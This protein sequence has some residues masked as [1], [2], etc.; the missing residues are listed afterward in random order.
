[1]ISLFEDVIAGFLVFFMKSPE[2][3]VDAVLCRRC[4]TE[5]DVGACIKL[6]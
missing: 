1:M 4:L 3:Y 6:V 2:C 5:L